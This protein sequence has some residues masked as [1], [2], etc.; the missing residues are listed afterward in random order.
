MKPTFTY[1]VMIMKKIMKRIISAVVCCV[2]IFSLITTAF[3]A[4]IYYYFGFSYTYLNNDMVSLYG[5]DAGTDYLFIPDTLNNRKLVDVRNNAFLNNT[6]IT[7][8]DLAGATNLE[9]IGSF[10]FANCSN[11]SG[12]FTIPENVVL[13]E[14]AAFENCTGL[15]NVTINAAVRKIP[16]QCFNGC[17][18]L[19]SVTLPDTVEAIG[20]YAFANCSSLEYIEIP[21]SVKEIASTAFMNDN[22]KLGVYYNSD[23]YQYAM[24]NGLAYTVLDPENI[25]TEPPT[26]TPTEAVTEAPTEAPTEAVTEPPTEIP[27]ESAQT[28]TFLLGDADGNGE[29]NIIDSTIIQRLMAKSVEDTDGMI[30]LRGDI[31]DN[32]LSINDAALLCRYLAHIHLDYPINMIVTRTIK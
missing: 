13:I 22:V 3:A 28:V 14:T 21:A 6:E 25:P 5:V 8:L 17:S 15:E 24:D 10:A 18:S 7:N 30:S 19:S 4:T 1:K 20:D 31:D 16:N 29:V 26:E 23:A 32:E 11:L 12:G 2:L 27:T 9:R